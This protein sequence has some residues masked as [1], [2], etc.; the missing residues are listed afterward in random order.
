RRPD[1]RPDPF[2]ESRIMISARQAAAFGCMTAAALASPWSQAQDA[3]WYGGVNLGRTAATI[4]QDRITRGL[5]SQ[6]L[7]T[8]GFSERDRDVG[9]KLFGGYQLNRNFAIEGGW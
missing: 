6:G 3:G 9:Y 1:A 7:A 5:A 8:S 2:Q 4:D